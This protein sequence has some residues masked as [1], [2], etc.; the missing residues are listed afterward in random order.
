[1]T[2]HENAAHDGML[3]AE[4]CEKLKQ[5]IG[6]SANNAK[7]VIVEIGCYRGGTT[8][9]IADYLINTLGGGTVYAIDPHSPKIGIYGGKFGPADCI[10]F[11]QNLVSSGVTQNVTHICQ[12]SETAA[13]D[14]DLSIDLLL[15]DGDHSY[16]GVVKDIRLWAR[17]V[18]TGGMIV[19]DDW[20]PGSA[21]EH[22]GT[23]CIDMNEFA[24]FEAHG[25]LRAFR[26]KS[27]LTENKSLPAKKA[28]AKKSPSLGNRTLYLAA[29]LQSG[30]TTL[31]S[32]C[33][34]Q[35]S[36]MDGVLDLPHDFLRPMPAIDAR[37]G[38]AKATIACFR[39]QEIAEYY[40][41]QGWEI[42]PLLVVR[43][44]R[45]AYASLK[46]KWYGMNGTTA[47]DPPLR[48]RL[49]RFLE[50]WQFFVESGLPVVRY[51]SLVE[52]ASSTLRSACEA[53]DLPW[54]EAMLSWPKSGSEIADAGSGNETFFRSL[55]RGGARFALMPE[56]VARQA[57]DIAPADLEWIAEKFREYDRI[58]QYE[59]TTESV[60]GKGDFDLPRFQ[61]TRRDAM[62]KE[63]RRTRRARKQLQRIIQH[64]VFGRGLRMWALAIN[65]A[66]REVITD[67]DW[68]DK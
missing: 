29:G 22:A 8:I 67:D 58:N 14:W 13:K 32:W 48:L 68:Q 50:D 54:D 20:M 53:L 28:G 57:E 46:G 63:L 59:T 11:Q 18:R 64:P 26:R 42:R 7:A 51:E 10:H 62:Q 4:E 5:W 66:F 12:E 65:P 35:R 6:V 21:V 56:K 41:W 40:R 60:D 9:Q 2:G 34:L 43:D 33:F 16:N 17:H 39:Y 25:K 52:D 55:H 3:S 38:W 44:V 47:E 19:F 45:S 23:D 30:G 15:I 36:D 31:L 1:M 27:S 61:D 24:L 37:Y 49:L